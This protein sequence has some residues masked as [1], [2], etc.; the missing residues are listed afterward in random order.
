MIKA[1]IAA[2]GF[3]TLREEIAVHRGHWRERRLKD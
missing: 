1:D 3:K 2:F